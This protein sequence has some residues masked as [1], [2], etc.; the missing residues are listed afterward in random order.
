MIISAKISPKS[1]G[2]HLEVMALEESEKE[3]LAEELFQLSDDYND[4]TYSD[5]GEL[6]NSSDEILL[7]GLEDH[8]PLNI[9]CEAC[10]F[11]SCDEFSDSEETESMF[12]GP[13]CSFALI[14]LGMSIGHALNT[15]ENHNVDYNIS[16]KGGIAGRSLGLISSRVCLAVLVKV[17]SDKSYHC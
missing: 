9:D 8:P 3:M 16:I 6:V 2:D 12:V 15:A 17:V 7:I 14:D 5:E 11:S 4:D 1:E 10:G 13:N